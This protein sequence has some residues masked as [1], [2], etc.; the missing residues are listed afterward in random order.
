M[1]LATPTIQA[2]EL[3]SKAQVKVRLVLDLLALVVLQLQSPRRL[4]VSV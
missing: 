4:L 2:L 1:I 3:G